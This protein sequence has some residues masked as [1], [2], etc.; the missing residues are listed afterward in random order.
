[1]EDPSPSAFVPS[2]GYAAKVISLITIIFFIMVGVIFF[3]SK[4][5]EHHEEER[6][7]LK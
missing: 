5:L 1:M 6:L 4:M 2:L 3:I 7:Q